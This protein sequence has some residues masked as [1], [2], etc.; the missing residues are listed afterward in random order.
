MGEGGGA[1]HKTKQNKTKQNGILEVWYLSNGI[2]YAIVPKHVKSMFLHMKSSAEVHM[3][4][5]NPM[6]LV[7]QVKQ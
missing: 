5:T 3:K 6:C 4:G 7:V 1:Y 2:R